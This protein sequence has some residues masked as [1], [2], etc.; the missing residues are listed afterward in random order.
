MIAVPLV[1][2]EPNRQQPP[3]TRPVSVASEGCSRA[4]KLSATL[5]QRDE[6]DV[7]DFIDQVG[8]SSLQNAV[9]PTAG[10]SSAA[11]ATFAACAQVIGARQQVER[12]VDA[13]GLGIGPDPSARRRAIWDI[14]SLS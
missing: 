6:R 12:K 14:C 8:G 11:A 1:A 13:R 4:T 7:E 2:H 9:R 3:A 10:T 5:Q